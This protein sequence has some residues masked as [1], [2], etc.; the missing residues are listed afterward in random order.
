MKKLASGLLLSMVSVSAFAN[1]PTYK[2]LADEKATFE[3][4]ESYADTFN[5]NLLNDIK[6][7][8]DIMR[9]YVFIPQ[10]EI[11]NLEYQT[12]QMNKNYGYSKIGDYVETLH[13]D[14]NKFAKD[15]FI[16]YRFLLKRTLNAWYVSCT[17]YKPKD[18]WQL[19]TFD[20]YANPFY[21]ND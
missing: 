20:F 17:F 4:C 16:Q 13:I 18:K 11:D 3:L 12:N 21:F 14:T 19:H 7:A 6:P 1:T 2:T 5:K 8:Y 15:N 10:I 9:P